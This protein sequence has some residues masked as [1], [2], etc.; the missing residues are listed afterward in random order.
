[1]GSGCESKEKSRCSCLEL[2]DG[3]V[4]VLQNTKLCLNLEKTSMSFS[5]ISFT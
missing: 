1:M 3:S 2:N 5:S 4:P